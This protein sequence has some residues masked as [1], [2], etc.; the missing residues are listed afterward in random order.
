MGYEVKLYLGEVAAPFPTETRAFLMEVASVDLC[1]VGFDFTEHGGVPVYLYGPD[2]GNTRTV[3]DRYGKQ[4]V[5]ITPESALNSLQRAAKR[6]SYR[7][8]DMAIALLETFI[9][10]KFDNPGVVVYGH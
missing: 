8:Y 7:R 1:K 2:G 9:A 5:A 4:L 10:G 6:D 3:E